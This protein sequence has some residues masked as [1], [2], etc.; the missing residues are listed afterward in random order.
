MRRKLVWILGGGLLAL[1]GVGLGIVL[2]ARLDWARPVKAVD[3]A[4]PIQPAGLFGGGSPA[5][6][7]FSELA[8]KAGRC[9]VNISTMKAARR[10][11]PGRPRFGPQDPFDDF[12]ERFFQGP[13]DRPQR[14]L[15]SGFIINEEGYILTNNHVIEEADEI[16]VQLTDKRRLDAK[17]IGADPKTDLAVIK[18]SAKNLPAAILGDS[19]ALKVGDWVMAVGNPFGLDHTVTA[20]IVSAKGR[21]IGAG[22]YDDFIQT[23]AS[24]NPGNSGGPL[25]NLKGEVIGVNSAIVAS[26]QGI[27]FAIPINMA[28]DLVPQ[29]IKSGKVTRAWL[30]VGI[31]EI[32]PELAESF[33]MKEIRGALV[34]NVFPKSPAAQG[35]LQPGDI[36]TEF[37]G[38][39]IKESHDLPSLVA[40]LPIGKRAPL[41]VLRDGKERQ[42][43]V[44]L[45]ERAEGER[46]AME[47]TSS[48]SK[49]LG[50]AVRDLTPEE[51]REAGVDSGIL[52][53][54]V[55]PGGAADFAGCQRG[56]IL[57]S[58]NNTKLSK[59]TEFAQGAQKIKPGQVVRLHLKRDDQTIFL[60]FM[61]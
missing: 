30:G 16:Q 28:K 34:S 12:F 15:G 2:T 50:L 13:V 5:L 40:R 18:V 20:G 25:F 3:Y 49:E 56:D 52:I 57:L 21:V 27:G 58:I 46:Q 44:V 60:A 54:G 29:L 22:P 24:I 32:T 36:V 23:D 6:P 59:T 33:G 26:G 17:V 47:E 8:E 35:G 38:V 4:P 61:K 1:A 41:K 10:S 19:G 55:E 7:S 48:A 39:A 53:I 43:F 42:L 45:G 9:V 37:D 31:Q 51:M 14:S 11:P